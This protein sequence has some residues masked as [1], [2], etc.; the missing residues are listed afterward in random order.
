MK[1]NLQNLVGYKMIAGPG[2][3]GTSGK[4]FELFVR[5]EKAAGDGGNSLVTY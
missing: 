4:I 1:E 2:K 5:E 3:I